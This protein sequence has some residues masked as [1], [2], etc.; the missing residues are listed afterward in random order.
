MR[1]FHHDLDFINQT[2]HNVKSL[3]DGCLGF[4]VG[5]SIESLKDTFY[6]FFS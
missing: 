6:F 5:E 4:L 3:S 2:M 1:T